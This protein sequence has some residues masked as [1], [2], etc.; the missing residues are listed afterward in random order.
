MGLVFA[1]LGAVAPAQPQSTAS[2]TDATVRAL[3]LEAER[4]ERDGDR[5][6]AVTTLDRA[7][8][9]APDEPL[10][11]GRLGHLLAGVQ[12]YRDARDALER[13]LEL[14]AGSPE[15]PPDER[16]R[17]L[18]DAALVAWESADAASAA[19]RFAE[20]A[21][22]HPGWGTGWLM[23]GR[24]ELWS[25]APA[26]AASA[27][28]RARAAGT[29]G[30]V[31][32]LEEGRALERLARSAA[33]PESETWARRAA[34]SYRAAV[35]AAPHHSEARYGLGRALQLLG[36]REAAREELARYQELYAE[37][38]ER[39]RREG[40]AGARLAEARSLL[41]RG[42]AEEAAA[43]LRRMP[44]TADVLLELS[45]AEERAGNLPAALAAL[46]RAVSLEPRRTDL[47]VRLAALL[48]RV[49]SG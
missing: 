22:L 31:L 9:A 13:A 30:L 18:L 5:A 27:F 42:R 49:T 35:E 32:H 46:Q 37:D 11:L 26:A 47:Q 21:E 24:Y 10:V 15:V 44:P 16:R 36:D 41:A 6:G 20:L 34:D 45:R 28:E 12:R 7:R 25:G 29:T 39:L 43:N 2:S 8:R 3:V 14:T 40:V 38:Q 17:W 48:E 23:R 33:G 19:R 1:A 4:L